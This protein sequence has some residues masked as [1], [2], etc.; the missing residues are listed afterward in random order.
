MARFRRRASA[1]QDVI[2]LGSTEARQK[3]KAHS[4]VVPPKYIN[5][6]YDFAWRGGNTICE[7]LPRRSPKLIKLLAELNSKI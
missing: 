4:S 6:K 7:S 1:V 5:I 2:Q 3:H